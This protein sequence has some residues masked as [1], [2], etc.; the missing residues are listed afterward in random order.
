MQKKV[1]ARTGHWVAA[2]VIA[3]ACWAPRAMAWDAAGH[4]M[5]TSAALHG[6]LRDGGLPEWLGTPE[7]RA[8]LEFQSSE[9]DRWRGQPSLTLKHFAHP[10]HYIDVEDLED[11]G[12][13]LRT[14]PTFR[15][16]YLKAMIL[17]RAADPARFPEY[18]TTK[19]PAREY[20]WPG[21]VPYAVAEHYAKLQ[22]SFRTL[23]I[24]EGLDE[25]GR[26]AQVAQERANVLYHMGALSHFVGD[27]AQPLHTTRH[28][29]GWV[30]E[31]PNGYTTEWGFHAYI[32][33]TILVIHGI[34][35]SDIIEAAAFDRDVNAPDPWN[36]TIEQIERS[37]AQMEPLYKLQKDGT[38]EQEAGKAFIIARL[39]D[40]SEVLAAMYRAA[41]ETSDPDGREVRMFMGWTPPVE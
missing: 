29:H 2:G 33:G 25:P 26:E 17:A 4:R 41:W 40:A 39:A 31:N 35:M 16:E 5:V 24:L 30:G 22:A 34:G 28:H 10:D 15:N 12:L 38:L 19:D 11:Y 14:L 13:S 9:P 3:L 1:V 36:D 6:A 37:F 32:D 27:I 7:A 21:F 18:D 23:K 20:E 8:R